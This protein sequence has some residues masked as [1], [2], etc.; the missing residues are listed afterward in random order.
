[1]TIRQDVLRALCFYDAIG[2]PPTWAEV[3]AAADRGCGEDAATEMLLEAPVLLT[4]GRVVFKG[5]ESLIEVHERRERLL[6]R[7]LRRARLVTRWLVRLGGVR[8]VA[9]CNTTALAHADEEGDLDFFMIVRA[10]S[11][12]QTR[13]WSALPFKLFGLRP[14]TVEAKDAVCLSFFV[15]DTAL[16]LAPLALAGDDVYLRHWFLSLLPLYDDG[17]STLFWE[18]NKKLRQSHPNAHPWLVHPR[19]CVKRPFWRIPFFQTAEM[20]AHR[21]QERVLSPDIRRQM[22]QGTH[23]VVTDHVLKFHVGDGRE[24]YRQACLERCQRYGVAS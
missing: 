23:V 12:W 10:G 4:R 13:G 8:F 14:T 21:M 17:V 18:Q 19:L 15:D 9:I 1:M 2:Y 20:L 7:K 24:A 11:L 16:D 6:A 5:R 3:Q 22:N